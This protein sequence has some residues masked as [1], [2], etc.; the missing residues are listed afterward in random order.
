MLGDKYVASRLSDG[1]KLFPPHIVVEINGLKVKIPGFWKGKEIFIPYDEIASVSVNSRLIGFSTL[2]F[3][4]RGTEVA[5]HGFTKSQV[6]DIKRD[7]ESGQSGYF[8]RSKDHSYSKENRKDYDEDE[9]DEEDED[10]DEYDEE[11]DEE[12]DDRK[13]NRSRSMPSAPVQQ[14][15]ANSNDGSFYDPKLEKLIDFALA[16]GELTEKERQVLYAKATSM[17]IDLDEFEMILQS[18]LYDKQKEIDKTKAESTASPK[19]NKMGDI[20]KCPACG[21]IVS[22]YQVSCKE[23]GYEF[24]DI[25]ANSSAQLLADKLEMARNKI[26]RSQFKD[27]KSL[28]FTITAEESY[29]EAVINAQLEIIKTFPIPNTKAD[30]LE[31][32]TSLAPR[33]DAKDVDDFELQDAY[34]QKFQECCTKVELLFPEDPMFL[35]FF[36]KRRKKGFWGKMRNTFN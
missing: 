30:L 34:K 28:G 15:A 11:E 19:S 32:L 6:E 35:S 27:R 18:K 20:K 24:S 1:N 2:R 12:Y 10:E 31:F 33:V 13:S 4:T 5:V 9:Y 14:S 23:C 17:G 29:E 16:D 36:E 8:K 3:Y 26:K 21:A 7:I 25:K 22:S